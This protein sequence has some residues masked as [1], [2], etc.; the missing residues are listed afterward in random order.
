MY[1]RV[2]LQCIISLVYIVLGQAGTLLEYIGFVSA[3]VYVVC[4][5]ML[6]Y[7][8]YSQPNRPRAVKVSIGG[9]SSSRSSRSGCS[10]RCGGMGSLGY[11][12]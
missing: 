10:V 4:I 11:S 3:L 5:L 7:L 12:V 9:D 2:T 1:L 8:R 6:L